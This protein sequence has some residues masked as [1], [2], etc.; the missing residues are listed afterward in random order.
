[1]GKIGF[2][3]VH[4]DGEAFVLLAQQVRHGDFNVVKLDES[5]AWTLSSRLISKERGSMGD[6]STLGKLTASKNTG[7]V[8]LLACHAWS[9]EWDDECRHAGNTITTSPHRSSAVIGKEAICD[10]LLGTVDDILVTSSLGRSCDASD[11]R[12]SCKIV[13]VSQDKMPFDRILGHVLTIWLSNTEAESCLSRQ[14]VRQ[15]AT[16][17]FRVTELNKRWT[18]D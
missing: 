3:T 17:L 6:Y 9:L 18:T 2:L 8:N 10:P 13:R 5:R 12:T 11:I 16:L 15:E 1:M 4:D 7:V 14:N